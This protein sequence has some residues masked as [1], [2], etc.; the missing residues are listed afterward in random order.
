[1]PPPPKPNAYDRH[2]KALLNAAK[3]V[4]SNTMVDSGIEIHEL[5]NEHVDDIS[6]CGV[7]C[8]GTWQKRGYSSMN[9]CVTTISMDTGKCLDVE[10]LSK[11]CQG[12]QR[13]EHK[14][15]TE[16]KRIWKADHERK[17]KANYSGSAPSM[18]TEGV[19]RIFNRSE[20]Q[21]KLQYT[22][23]FGDGDSKGFSAVENTYRDNGVTVIKK[24]CVG[25]VQKRVG[26]A[27]R[28][29]K[30][31][32]KGMGGKGK[33]TD[34]MIDRLQNY[35]GIAIR[36]NVGNLAEMKKAIHASLF[37][38]ASSKERDLH[39][40]CPNGPDSWCRRN[41]DIANKTHLYKPGAG[42]PVHIINELK[43]I[44]AR[45]S[46]DVLLERCLDGKTQNQNES[47]NGMIWDHL[48]KGVF[49]GSDTLNLGVFDAVGHFNIGCQSAL[50]VL[51]NLGMDP[52]KF[53]LGG[54]Q[55]I[56]SLRINKSVYKA[57]NKKK[58]KILRAQRKHKGDKA[59]DHEGV[60]YAPGGF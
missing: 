31:E 58:R 19:K 8:D 4:A 39:H 10:V 12:C 11:V 27:L 48:P 24:E 54:L 25:H 52:G 6:Q 36:T 32:K 3:T 30:K 57:E 55:G 22:E 35:Y 26:T 13:H 50:N 49:V 46:D 14:P 2:N 23:Y 9:G 53:C 20:E 44:Y 15:D 18:E 28:K 42:L 1:M 43:P 56:D 51:I 21:H 37:H 5:K 7:S 40:H 41:K 34:F 33:L 45:L 16:E 59:K 17:C 47:L 38:C 60:T 29:L